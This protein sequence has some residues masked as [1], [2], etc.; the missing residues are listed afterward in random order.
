[1]LGA[2][3]GRTRRLP[4]LVATLAAIAVLALPRLARAQASP[5]HVLLI[6]SNG[7]DNQAE[8]LTGSL[9]KRFA[10]SGRDWSVQNSPDSFET[11]RL[12]KCAPPKQ[13]DAACLQVVYGFLK[14]VPFVW[15]TLVK[16][17]GGN[18]FAD[19]HLYKGPGKP[20]QPAQDTFSE[21]LSGE[22]YTKVA[23]RLYAKLNNLTPSAFITVHAGNGGGSV[24]VD[25]ADKG[26]LDPQGAA[27]VEVPTGQHAIEVR[28][29]GFLPA[30]QQLTVVAGADQELPAFTLT[31][32]KP[33]LPAVIGP[34]SSIPWRRVAAFTAMGL[35][36]ASL[37]I[38]TVEGVRFL[39][40][41]SDL[42]N[43]RNNVP[44]TVTNVCQ[45]L[46]TPASIDACS[47]YND[48]TNARVL[49]IVFLSVGAVLA[50]GGFV[51]L[52][53]DK[54]DNKPSDATAPRAASTPRLLPS[55]SRNSAGLDFSVRW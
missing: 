27:T 33:E 23:A 17:E 19:L 49:E 47:K 31:Q 48:A 51:L 13:A 3:S 7:P 14:S 26:S 6:E 15:G 34:A 43:D 9:R 29:P 46:S 2:P 1:M 35:G 20:D 4:L 39:G 28:V 55:F 42:D 10:K 53:T 8:Q 54:P 24:F 30:T 22:D 37:I 18:L 21:N 41:K 45:D 32:A 11:I 5:I 40:L 36:A 44:N 52:I 38:G 12:A 25:G 50:G 16:K